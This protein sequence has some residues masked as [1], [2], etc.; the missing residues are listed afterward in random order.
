VAPHDR[1]QELDGIQIIPLARP[2]S[3]MVRRL[4]LTFYAAIIAAK[5][6][7]D[8]YHFHD[9]ELIPAMR[10]LARLLGKPVVWD[11]HES[12]VDTIQHFNVL[13]IPMLSKA[14]SV[15]FDRME[16]FACKNEFSGVVTITETMADRYRSSGIRTCALGNYSDIRLIPYPP[17]VERSM[18]PRFISAGGHFEDR[19]VLK[20]ADAFCSVWQE[21]S[22]E[23]AFW[24]YFQPPSLEEK[25]RTLIS[26]KGVPDSDILIGGPYPWETLINELI[27]TGWVGCIL[28]NNNDSS[29]RLALPNRLFEYWSLALPVVVSAGTEAAR[30]VRETG[31]GIVLEDNS[32]QAI[33]D[34]FREFALNPALVKRMG[35]AGRKVVEEKYNWEKIF[36]SLLNL[37]TDLGVIP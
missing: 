15:W 7:A 1:E 6:K 3:T 36:P 26:A 21:I 13:G 16:I 11:A 25:L 33:A 29:G 5:Q 9:P 20:M 35:N 27:P 19:E 31:G 2:R 28:I 32:S 4:F 23:I 8:L 34:V 12:Y 30:Y 24:G 22:C 10:W 18:R 17:R 37:Y 14:V